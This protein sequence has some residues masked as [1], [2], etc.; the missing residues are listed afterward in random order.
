MVRYTY[1]WIC[2]SLTRYSATCHLNFFPN[3]NDIDDAFEHVI[4]SEDDVARRQIEEDLRLYGSRPE[5]PD[6]VEVDEYSQLANLPPKRSASD[7]EAA[8]DRPTKLRE[9]SES[10]EFNYQ[11]LPVMDWNSAASPLDA[12]LNQSAVPSPGAALD[13]QEST[14]PVSDPLTQEIDEIKVFRNVHM[15]TAP[16]PEHKDPPL[17]L[18]EGL[19]F[20]AQIYYR[21]IMDRYPVIPKYLARRLAVANC[22]RA[23]RLRH[24]K[25]RVQKEH[26]VEEKTRH[27]VHRQR[28]LEERRNE[29]RRRTEHFEKLNRQLQLLKEMINDYKMDGFV[30]LSLNHVS[31]GSFNSRAENPAFLEFWERRNLPSRY[32]KIKDMEQEVRALEAKMHYYQRQNDIH[33]TP[34]AI[35]MLDW[36][37][38]RNFL[39]ENPTSTSTRPCLVQEGATCLPMQPAS[40]DLCVNQL[41]SAWASSIDGS[42]PLRPSTPKSPTQEDANDHSP[43]NNARSP[44]LLPPPVPTSATTPPP[45]VDFWTRGSQSSRPASVHSRSSSMNS[46]LH[47]RPAFDPQEQ[48]PIFAGKF[49]DSKIDRTGPV[50]PPAPV[51]LGRVTTFDCDICG[52]KIEVKRRREWQ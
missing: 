25:E 37:S 52:Q 31:D 12:W 32:L 46:S 3:P 8:V 21:N 34:N 6:T 49:S 41:A 30:M 48:D 5:P 29:E 22:D 35:K 11:A 38:F 28:E 18:V 7:F 47:G 9:K 4:V 36:P 17:E 27:T 50:L 33:S 15:A 40:E 2:R 13:R 43:L 51:E 23:E 44:F 16:S 19:D 26:E 42:H 39:P 45:P 10:K 20:G 14:N 24:E 1:T